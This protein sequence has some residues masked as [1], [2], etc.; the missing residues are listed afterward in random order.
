M[1]RLKVT[2]LIFCLSIVAL[3]F[4]PKVKGVSRLCI[5]SM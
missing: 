2:T 4:Q 1:N 5:D 3:A